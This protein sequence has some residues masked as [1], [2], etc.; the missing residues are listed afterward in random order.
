MSE[1]SP[2]L[3]DL[4]MPAAPARA[5]RPRPLGSVVRQFAGRALLAAADAVSLA[6]ALG[7]VVVVAE[8]L[9]SYRPVLGIAERAAWPACIVAVLAVGFCLGL[10]EMTGRSA[11]ERFR[12]RAWSALLMPIVGLA[13]LAL[14]DAGNWRG[15]V[16]FG[17]AAAIWLPLSMVAEVLAVRW[18]VTR[19]AWG[20]R[21]L[22]IGDAAGAS[23]MSDY[24]HA[25]PEIG[26][27]PVG[28]CGSIGDGL[29]NVPRFGSLAHARQMGGEADIAIVLLSPDV[30]AL[31]LA[32]LPF[33]RVLV[34]PEATG[35][36]SLWLRSRAVGN[37]PALEFRHPAQTTANL[38]IKRMFDLMVSAP[39]LV[40][41]LPIILTLAAIVFVVSPGPVL[42]L[43][44]R[45]GWNGRTLRMLKLRSM[46][47]NAEQRLQDLLRADPAAQAEW[48]RCVKLSRDPRV[49][50]FIG[51]FIR[52]TSL[53]E[54]PQL[55]NVLRGEMSIVGPRPFPS[56]HLDL[57]DA[58]FQTLR[59]SVRPGLTGLWQVS[60]RSDANLK[61]QQM[62]DTFYIRNWS[63]W[64][65]LYITLRTFPAILIPQ[66]A[67]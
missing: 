56:Y 32:S 37:S 2:P 47:L 7:I 63:L 40:F 19:S 11:V 1:T 3:S 43:Q 16:A 21:A 30:A 27:R 54:L 23:R 33:R 28:V 67:R 24:L 17:I 31:D 59:A 34:L 22:L 42:Y 45:T 64:F 5:V 39:V 13:M 12:L 18:L 55:W 15:L 49:L 53:D 46:H 52:R 58:E 50:P 36:P 62:L 25:H 35:L 60:E 10:Y 29:S 26:L 65:D 8:A 14:V 44:R 6:A 41:S 38:R 51:K 61:Q 9:L 48:D 4:L 66:G 20:A 57:F